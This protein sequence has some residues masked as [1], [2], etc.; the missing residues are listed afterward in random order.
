[1][2][3]VTTASYQPALQALSQGELQALLG[4]RLALAASVPAERYSGFAGKLRASIAG[5]RAELQRRQ[6]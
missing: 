2:S 6:S 4:K 3:L 1:M 5:I